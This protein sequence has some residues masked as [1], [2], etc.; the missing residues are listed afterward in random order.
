MSWCDMLSYENFKF[1]V[2]LLTFL[3][4]S[5]IKGLFSTFKNPEILLP[6]Y[7]DRILDAEAQ[8]SIQEFHY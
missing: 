4:S 6:S 1:H 2:F 3:R 5:N 7:F 8:I